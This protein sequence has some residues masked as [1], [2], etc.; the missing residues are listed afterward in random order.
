MDTL[1]NAQKSSEEKELPSSLDDIEPTNQEFE[2]LSVFDII[3][4]DEEEGEEN[5]ENTNDDQHGNSFGDESFEREDTDQIY[6][7]SAKRAVGLI[8]VGLP[9]VLSFYSGEG[10]KKYKLDPDEKEELEDAFFNYE[11]ETKR[12]L[13]DPTTALVASVIAIIGGK[14]GESYA[15]KEKAKASKKQSELIKKAKSPVI[16]QAE[17]SAIEQ[18]IKEQKEELKAIPAQE[19]RRKF[20]IDWKTGKYKYDGRTGRYMTQAEQYQVPADWVKELV[21]KLEDDGKSFKEVNESVLKEVEKGK[22]W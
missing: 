15:D 17:K 7:L 12:R 1:L 19:N 5:D 6:R 21:K 16:T 3:S 18:E 8:N 4:D 2:T 20:Q 11:K 22:V 14:F 9:R 10:Y 13:L